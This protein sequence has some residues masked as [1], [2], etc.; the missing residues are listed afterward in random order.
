MAWDFIL[1]DLVGVPRSELAGA[2]SKNVA[3]PIRAMATGRITVPLDHDDAGF[4]LDGDALLKVYRNDGNTRTL[5]AH[6]RLVTAV[7][8]AREGRANVTATFADPFWVLLKRLLGRDRYGFR[9]T[10]VAWPSSLDRIELF[11]TVLGI[12]AQESA[13]GVELGDT[14]PSLMDGNTYGPVNFKRVADVITEL[15][16]T[17]GGPDWRIRPVEPVTTTNEYHSAYAS[18]T[19]TQTV[20]GK[21]DVLAAIGSLKAD[22]AFE[23][24]DGR[25]NV[26]G[27]Q[28]VVSNEGRAN[29]LWHL[30]QGFPDSPTQAPISAE[31][32]DLIASSVG[33][34]EEVV[35]ADIVPDVLRTQLV[36][37]H[38]AVRKL[39]RQTITFDVAKDVAGDGLRVP[40]VG[41]DVVAGD[42]VPFRASVQTRS[43]GLEK[44][45]DAL[46]RVYQYEVNVDDH[47]ADAVTLTVAPS[48]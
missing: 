8:D 26:T 45:V 36:Q 47:G 35:N 25:L 19:Y 14:Q 13:T 1:T 38:L 15:C 20:I 46:F 10:S 40:R 3:I 30:P 27:Y 24:G 41:I 23:Y 11:N 4:L 32:T 33:L 16:A 42:V 43:R 22:H 2:R 21:L 12:A 18:K 28:R 37:Y 7:E 44:R 17:A 34:L 5:I 39:A 9:W 31:D 29:R 6:L 48:A